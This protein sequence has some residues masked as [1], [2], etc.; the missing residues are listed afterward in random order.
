M[1][2]TTNTATPNDKLILLE[3]LRGLAGFYVLVF[4]ARWLLWEGYVEGY[5]K[6]V[7]DYD[8]FSKIVAH[9]FLLFSFGHQFVIL[10]FVLSGFV[11]HLRYARRLSIDESATRFDWLPYVLRRTR[12]LY[13]PLI[14]ALVLT[15]VIDQIGMRLG[16]PVYTSPTVLNLELQPV[17]GWGVAL[18]NL[19]FMMPILAPSWGSNGVLW[20]LTYEWWFYMLYPLLWLLTRRSITLA[21]FVVIS[22]F[23]VS[24][25]PM[26]GVLALATTVFS[27]LLTWWFGVLLADIYTGR[28]KLNFAMM[29]PL[30]AL[31]A[32]LAPIQILAPATT[33]VG[34]V[35]SD[36]GWGLAFVGLI[37]LGFSMQNRGWEKLLRPL[38]VFKW[39]A[40]FSYTLY[41]TH[42]PILL[43]MAGWLL[44]PSG[45]AVL[46]R[47]VA[48]VFVG[49]GV[50]LL[51]AY[52]AHFV[53]ERPFL[54]QSHRT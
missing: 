51:V 17:Y 12:R 50:S 45:G 25:V 29:V 47:S 27:G 7:A 36:V 4:H 53:T 35:I 13:P 41:V 24:F 49:I 52:A 20:S 14:F 1:Q 32:I 2:D 11:I 18:G 34:S 16:F 3:A 5:A 9:L 10:F 31:F 23:A 48:W 38:Y 21:T 26:G 54:R 42:F 28:I 19:A 43:F 15:F 44:L 46:P 8:I 39:L 33:A 40:P 37:S 6:H 22:C 30:T